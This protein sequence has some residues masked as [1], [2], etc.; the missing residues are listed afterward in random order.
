M[1]RNWPYF[2]LTTFVLYF[3]LCMLVADANGTQHVKSAIS[4]KYK[5]LFK[6]VVPVLVLPVVVG[7]V[8]QPALFLS[9]G[10]LILLIR[11]FAARTVGVFVDAMAW[12]WFNA[13]DEAIAVDVVIVHTASIVDIVAFACV[14][15]S[16]AFDGIDSNVVPACCPFGIDEVDDDGDE[17][18]DISITQM[19][20]SDVGNVLIE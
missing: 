10:P 3:K 1:P 4:N 15:N 14:A 16:C 8:Q 2:V 6:Y 13:T 5:C 12:L 11:W 18:V 20:F 19:A 9:C 17:G 7:I